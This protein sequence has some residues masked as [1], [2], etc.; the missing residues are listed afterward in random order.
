MIP[1]HNSTGAGLCPARGDRANL[2]AAIFSLEMSKTEIVMRLLSAEARVPLH[3]LRTGQLSDDDWT[4]LARCMGEITMRRS[5]S[6]TR[7]T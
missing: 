2:A 3:V 1:T 5:S 4:K 6:T 7:R